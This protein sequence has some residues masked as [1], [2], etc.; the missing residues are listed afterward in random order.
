MAVSE[1]IHGCPTLCRAFAFIL[2]ANAYCGQV[3]KAS[4]RCTWPCESNGEVCALHG[5]VQSGIYACPG[6]Q[7]IHESDIPAADSQL[8]TF[9]S[10]HA[11]LMPVGIFLARCWNTGTDDACP[12]NASDAHAMR[13]RWLLL[14]TALIPCAGRR[15]CV[16]HCGSVS[17]RGRSLQD[18]AR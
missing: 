13:S 7:V 17:G 8:Q 9:V 10:S 11:S 1:K 3:D 18:D 5:A 12:C 14:P 15:R 6:T 4:S 2:A 16:L